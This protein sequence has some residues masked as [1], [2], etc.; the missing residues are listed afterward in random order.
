MKEARAR[1]K[2]ASASQKLA[3]EREQKAKAVAEEAQLKWKE[4]DDRLQEARAEK[5]AAIRELAARM[6]SVAEAEESK[7]DDEVI[8]QVTVARREVASATAAMEEAAPADQ[9]TS[10]QEVDNK[11]VALNDALERMRAGMP[12]SQQT[13]PTKVSMQ[14]AADASGSETTALGYTAHLKRIAEAA[15]QGATPAEI[16]AMARSGPTEQNCAIPPPEKRLRSS[17]SQ[18][19][20][21]ELSPVTDALRLGL[22]HVAPCE[23]MPPQATATETAEATVQVQDAN[24]N[25]EV[26]T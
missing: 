19:K 1:D 8:R 23:Q 3:E 11:V 24:T 17:E 26:E 5:S 16:V 18:Q 20:T 9:L 4:A 21:E 15:E 7:R 10:I 13:P 14:A 6:S 25:M 22:E 12:A 2:K